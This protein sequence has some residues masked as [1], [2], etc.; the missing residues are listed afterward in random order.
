MPTVDTLLAS[1][2]AIANEWRPLAFAWHLALMWCATLVLFGW[3]PTRRVIAML[4]A[5]PLVSVSAVA[6]LAGNPF[7]GIVFAAIAATLFAIG[8]GLPLRT[9]ASPSRRLMSAGGV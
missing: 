5:T 2:A 8:M 9:V 4:I 7:N 1:A 6:W 3:R